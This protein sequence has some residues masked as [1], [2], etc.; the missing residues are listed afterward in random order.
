MSDAVQDPS[1]EARPALNPCAVRVYAYRRSSKGLRHPK[2]AHNADQP[3]RQL[4][5]RIPLFL[6]E[7]FA[8]KLYMTTF[9]VLLL[10]S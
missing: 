8:W 2:N 1:A 10:A 3:C 9:L 4:S 6:V 5:C 7:P